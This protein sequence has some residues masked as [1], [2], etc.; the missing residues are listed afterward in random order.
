MVLNDIH[1]SVCGYLVKLESRNAFG[2]RLTR[3]QRAYF[4]TVDSSHTYFKSTTSHYSIELVRTKL[5]SGRH[6][7]MTNKFVWVPATLVLGAW[8]CWWWWR[9]ANGKWRLI[10]SCCYYCCLK[11]TEYGDKTMMRYSLLYC[12]WCE[13]CAAL[14]ERGERRVIAMIDTAMCWRKWLRKQVGEKHR[15]WRRHT[16]WMDVGSIGSE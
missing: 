8:W 9:G 1:V 4:Y 14:L 10:R 5:N 15:V 3:K 11:D 2:I 16:I 12:R 6:T 13:T 7:Y